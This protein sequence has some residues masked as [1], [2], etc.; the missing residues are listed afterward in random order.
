MRWHKEGWHVDVS[1]EGYKI[2]K[3][4]IDRVEYYRPS[5]HGSFISA[6]CKEMKEAQA[7]CDRHFKAARSK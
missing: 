2:A 4:R 5:L 6:P 3:F 7:V 1:D